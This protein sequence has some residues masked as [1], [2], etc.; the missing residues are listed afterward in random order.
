FGPVS[1][2]WHYNPKNDVQ[3]D[4]G[5]TED[6]QQHKNKPDPARLNAEIVT[7]P[8]AHTSEYLVIRIAHQFTL[9]THRRNIIRFVC[10]RIRLLGVTCL[11]IAYPPHLGNHIIDILH[12]NDFLF[13]LH[14]TL[15]EHFSDAV[16]YI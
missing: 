7:Q 4:S 12:R 16:F 2:Q 9:P 8:A 5:A 14:D 1:G 10:R 3:K 11:K 6:K 13:S 15:T